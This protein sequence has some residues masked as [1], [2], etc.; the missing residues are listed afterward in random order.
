MNISLDKISINYIINALIVFAVISLLYM[1]LHFLLP[2]ISLEH[3][4]KKSLD[5]E[6][7]RLNITKNFAKKPKV[8]IK[9]APKEKTIELTEFTLKSIY[10]DHSN[11]SD[12]FIIVVKKSNTKDSFL[13]SMGDKLAKQYTLIDIDPD[14]SEA[15]FSKDGIK[16]NMAIDSIKEKKGTNKGLSLVN[17]DTSQIQNTDNSILAIPRDK[18]LE[19][20]KNYK[21]IWK[22]IS[23]K[24]VIQNKKIIGFVIR[25][26]KQ[27]T[28]FANLG[29]RK[30]DIITHINDKSLKSY[31]DAFKIYYNID[32]MKRLKLSLLRDNEKKEI[33]YEV[34]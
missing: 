34:Y 26:I 29:L 9:E 16:Y 19:Y 21:S 23:I 17:S 27:G 18:I 12:S 2:S 4:A 6:Y 8:I 15:I 24:E 22:Q 11:Q 33:D 28:I 32:N 5:I 14:D 10:F 1:P 25:S 31:G 20:R 30:G 7:Y 13:I 3:I